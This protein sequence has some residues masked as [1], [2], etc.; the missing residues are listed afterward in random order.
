MSS[1]PI[2]THATANMLHRLRYE[3]GIAEESLGKQ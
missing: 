2:L 3:N 1:S